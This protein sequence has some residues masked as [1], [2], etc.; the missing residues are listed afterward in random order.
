MFRFGD[1]QHANNDVVTRRE[2]DL[3]TYALHRPF[4]AR[5]MCMSDYDTG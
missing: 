1:L 4:A 3:I 5:G 2:S